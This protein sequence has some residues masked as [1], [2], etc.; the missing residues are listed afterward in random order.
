MATP[1]HP[2]SRRRRPL[3]RLFLAGLLVGA[4]LGGVWA[5][6][7]RGPYLLEDIGW[8]GLVPALAAGLVFILI[9]SL[10]RRRPQR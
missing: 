9:G 7:D 4:T 8:F 6:L 3:G 2:G 10:V 5:W 1:H